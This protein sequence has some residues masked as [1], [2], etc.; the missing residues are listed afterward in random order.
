MEQSA[1]KMI[2]GMMAIAFVVFV[3]SGHPLVLLIVGLVAYT[4]WQAAKGFER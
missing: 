2:A 1:I 4:V 3:V